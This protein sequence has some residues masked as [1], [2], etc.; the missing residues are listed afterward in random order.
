M[1][2]RARDKVARR[3]DR[4]GTRETE[5]RV[6]ERSSMECNNVSFCCFVCNTTEML[7]SPLT[8]HSPTPKHA[9]RVPHVVLSLNPFIVLIGPNFYSE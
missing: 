5:E 6:R 8:R 4:H 7:F 2:A 1:R 9:R 3:R